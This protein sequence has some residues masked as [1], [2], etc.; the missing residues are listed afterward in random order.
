MTG[1]A[2]AGRLLP[3]S[4]R[5]TAVVKGEREKAKAMRTRLDERNT[6]HEPMNPTRRRLVVATSA[7]SAVA[8]AGS[9]TPLIASLWPSARARAAGAP[10][11]ADLSRVE[12]GELVTVEWRGRP[13]WLLH[14]TSEMINRLTALDAPLLDAKS[15]GSR[16]PAYCKNPQRS[17][18]PDYF[19]AVGI[20]THLGC[21]PN[22]RKEL[23]PA[24]LGPGWPGGFYCPCHGSRFDLAGRVFKG[25][26][27]PRNLDIPKHQYLGE[28][29]LLIGVDDE[30]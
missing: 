3:T 18:R 29:A 24:D 17:R 7:A 28:S 11:E 12:A 14:R 15:E 4:G 1:E 5:P 25:S 23:A 30:S 21:I 22:F 9:V 27:A 8:A 10:V 20:C 16:Q 26:P 2:R 13:V 19:V 6:S